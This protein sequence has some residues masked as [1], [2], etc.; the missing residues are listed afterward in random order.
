MYQQM[1][2]AKCRRGA[3]HAMVSCVWVF[4]FLFFFSADVACGLYASLFL[5][6]TESAVAGMR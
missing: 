5:L 3:F 4:F 6:V 2:K 1:V